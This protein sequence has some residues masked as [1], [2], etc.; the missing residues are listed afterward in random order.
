MLSSLSIETRSL[1]ASP[2]RNHLPL[3]T[4]L[5]LGGVELP[6]NIEFETLLWS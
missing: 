3:I 5:S 1:V 6:N 2:S 4:Y